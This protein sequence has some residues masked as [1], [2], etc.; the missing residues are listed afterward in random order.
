[1]DSIETKW[2]KVF[3][4]TK[5]SAILTSLATYIM[6]N[7]FS[8][9]VLGAFIQLS[10]ITNLLPTVFIFYL[11]IIYNENRKEKMIKQAKT[12]RRF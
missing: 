4:W 9:L 6:L 2:Q 10:L 11:S 5:H 7:V 12:A 3:R 8:V 1:M